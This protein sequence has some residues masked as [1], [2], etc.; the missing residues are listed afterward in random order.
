VPDAVLEMSALG[1]ETYEGAAA[2][3]EFTRVWWATFEHLTIN[4]ETVVDLGN[5]VVYAVYQQEGRPPGST[6]VVGG[7][8]AAISEW[9][10]GMITRLIYQYDTDEARAA[11]ERLAEERG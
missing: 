11:A 8:V 9:E 10:D 7:P 2:I 6:G 4:V 1:F 5:G 3:R